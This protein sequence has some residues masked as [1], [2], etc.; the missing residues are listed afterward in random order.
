MESLKDCEN[1]VGFFTFGEYFTESC[2]RPHF[3][4]QTMTV[5]ALSET[6]N[7][8]IQNPVNKQIELT[9]PRSDS[10]RFQL[11]KALSNL[12]ISTTQELESTNQQL[13]DQANKD[14]LTGLAN[15][16]L[17]DNTILDRLKE[18]SRA[19]SIISLILLDVDFF[20]QFNDTYGHVV[21]DSCLRGIAQVLKKN[22]KRTS[23]MSF[24]YGGEE[25]G[26][27][28]SFTDHEKA[29]MIA[30]NI[31][32]GVE[33]LAIPHENSE[34]NECVTVSIGVLTVVNP[35]HSLSPDHLISA[36][37]DLLYTAK[38]E[39]RNRMVGKEF[40]YK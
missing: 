35:P 7:C 1:G 39:G 9:T 23:D 22:V 28:L 15:R 26:C 29:L 27:I 24:R 6:D 12:I 13:A 2:K 8:P 17:F 16:R 40:S 18:H 19:S 11:L 21:G 36:C 30:N 20:K 25:F 4:Q 33:N 5:L 37:D 10:R 38:T 14:G 3:L 32:E 31:R 34:V